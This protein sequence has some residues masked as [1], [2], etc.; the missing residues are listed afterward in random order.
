VVPQRDR[1]GRI[2]LDLSFQVK[3]TQQA[4]VNETTAKDASTE[5]VGEL[6]NVV[7]RLFYFMAAVPSDEIIMFS[8]IDLWDGF[9]RMIV[10]DGAEWNF[11]YALPDLPGKPTRLVVPS[12]LQSPGYVCA[13]TETA[14][15]IVQGLVESTTVVL[16]Y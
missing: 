9:W 7:L 1:R 4:S 3:N 10:Q 13:A 6:G 8:K 2:I 12:A 15:D 5:P 16:V 14:R 11:A